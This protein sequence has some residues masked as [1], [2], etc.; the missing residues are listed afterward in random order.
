MSRSCS[1]RSLVMKA[2]SPKF[3]HQ[4]RPPYDGDRLGERRELAVAPVEAA[5]LDDDPTERRA[6]PAEELRR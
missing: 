5:R 4:R 6:V 3:S 2:Y 1:L